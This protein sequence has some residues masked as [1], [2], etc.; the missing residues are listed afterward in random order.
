[1]TTLY[2]A[3]FRGMSDSYNGLLPPEVISIL[4][5]VDTILDRVLAVFDPI[6]NNVFLRA[7]LPETILAPYKALKTAS[8]ALKS[9]I[10]GRLPF[11]EVIDTLIM[12]RDVASS[13]L[14][15]IDAVGILFGGL[16]AIRSV[17]SPLRDVVGYIDQAIKL[18]SDDA[19]ESADP[20]IS[21]APEQTE[22]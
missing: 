13:L 4:I 5:T 2:V 18:I 7:F 21:E 14:D 19:E 8:L 1:M 3:R 20:E 11:A 15:A 16:S 17:T 22:A 6:L 12:I 9:I 10:N